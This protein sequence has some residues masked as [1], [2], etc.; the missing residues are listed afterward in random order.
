VPWRPRRHRRVGAIERQ[1]FYLALEDGFSRYLPEA[2]NAY[3]VAFSLNTADEL[4]N[5][6]INAGF[7]DAEFASSTGRYAILR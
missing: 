4:R 3:D 5:L 7:R 1:P 6:A 2:R